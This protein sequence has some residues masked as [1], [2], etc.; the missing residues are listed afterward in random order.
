VAARFLAGKGCSI[1]ARNV[2]CGRGEID[3]IIQDRGVVVAVVV[4]T[5]IDPV[6]HFTDQKIATLRLAMSRLQPSPRRLD[7]VTIEPDAERVIVQWYQNA[8]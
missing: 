1:L 8:G 5:G 2:R 4:Q 6:E 3:L 7:L